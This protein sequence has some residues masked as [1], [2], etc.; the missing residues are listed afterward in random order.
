MKTQKSSLAFLT[1]ILVAI[2]LWVETSVAA[3]PQIKGQYAFTGEASCLASTTVS[4]GTLVTPSGFNPDLTV[5]GHDFVISYSVQGVRRF[6]GNGTG[7][8]TGKTVSISYNNATPNAG[9]HTFTFDFTYVVAADGTV[10]TDMVPGTYQG[11][12]IAGPRTGQTVTVDNIE[13][14]GIISINNMTLTLATSAPTIETH[15]F[16]NG[17]VHQQICH[18]S[19]VLTWMGN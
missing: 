6:N 4:G 8:V 12:Y 14:D 18:R 1:A 11:L 2:F 10:T 3:P 13:L 9:S 5:K 15:T 7:T 17:D 16:S 19:R